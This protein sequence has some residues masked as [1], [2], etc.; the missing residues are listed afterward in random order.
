MECGNTEDFMLPSV[1]NADADA[2]KWQ[3]RA[4]QVRVFS[5]VPDDLSSV[6]TISASGGLYRRAWHRASDTT[7]AS[8]ESGLQ[9]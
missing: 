4:G 1:M 7:L 3:K 2:R 5:K 9:H 6:S 8:E